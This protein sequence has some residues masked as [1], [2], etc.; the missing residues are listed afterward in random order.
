[1]SKIPA[2]VTDSARD[3]NSMG[4]LMSEKHKDTAHG[5][6]IDHRLS[7]SFIV[8]R[9]KLLDFELL[10][11]DFNLLDVILSNLLFYLFYFIRCNHQ[12]SIPRH[13]GI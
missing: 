13:R 5:T 1:M 12:T 3:M 2:V 11:C 7:K 8:F 4:R 9:G 10:I 6:C